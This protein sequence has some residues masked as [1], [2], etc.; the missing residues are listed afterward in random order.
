ML[1]RL[2]T[3][4]SI[5]AGH[6]GLL[7]QALR[8]AWLTLE[9]ALAGRS[10]WARVTST[11]PPDEGNAFRQQMDA[12]LDLLNLAG[13]ELEDADTRRRF[14]EQ[15][16]PARRAGLLTGDGANEPLTPPALRNDDETERPALRSTA[17]R[18]HKAGYP[19]LAR[20]VLLRTPWD[21]PLFLGLVE[22]F[23]HRPLHGNSEDSSGGWWRCLETI[24]GILDEREEAVIG[25][26]DHLEDA[27]AAGDANAGQEQTVE[28]LFRLGLDR[29]FTGDYAQAATHFTAALKLAPANASLYAHRGDAYR[30]RGEY[31]RAIADFHAAL[32]L[33][34]P[35][36]STLVSRAAAY[37]H[38]SEYERALADCNAALE[39]TPNSAAAY[40]VRA[41]ANASLGSDEQA[42]TDLTRAIALDPED[43]EARY[44]RGVL[45]TQKKE[46]VRAV[47]DF[48]HVLGRN[49]RHVAAYLHR[50]HAH[51]GRGDYARAVGDFSTVLRYHPQS[52]VAYSCRGLAHR[53]N[54]DADRAI[55][56]YTAALRLE[57]DNARVYY[58]R[59]V[60]YR[61][62]GDLTRAL[63]DLDVTI[64]LEPGHWAAHYH[65]SKIALAQGRPAH[66]LADLTATLSFNPNLAVAYLSRALIHDMLNQ[67][68]DAIED[69]TQA[70]Q[71]EPASPVA[72]LVRG[73]LYSHAGEY[74][75]AVADLS[76]A[77]R[78]DA[79][80]ALAYH[81]RA[82][83]C[84]LLG[85]HDRALADCDR[86]L[87]LEPGN[88]QG[89]AQ[90]S[91]VYHLLGK[92]PEALTDYTRAV[93][94]DARC[95]MSGWN[96]GLAQVE[97][98]RSTR[99]LGDYLDGLRDQSPALEPPP[100]TF[101]IVIEPP[102]LKP[103]AGAPEHTKRR[104][105]KPRTQAEPKTTNY[106]PAA[107]TAVA[108]P[109]LKK[110]APAS[111]VAAARVAGPHEAS[112]TP[113]PVSEEDVEVAVDEIL[114]QDARVTADEDDKAEFI[115]NEPISV[116]QA[117]PGLEDGRV[118][119]PSCHRSAVPSERLSRGRVRCGMCGKVFI[120]GLPAADRPSLTAL[121]EVRPRRPAPRRAA[122]APAGLLER[123]KKPRLL[124]AVGVAA[125]VLVGCYLRF[126]TAPRRPPLYP[127][128]GKASFEG[129]P[130]AN[131]NIVLE[132]AWAPQEVFPRPHAVVK[133]DG[134]FVVGTYGKDDG[135]P[136]GEYKVLVTWL[137]KAPEPE[138]EG[139]ALP[140]NCLPD[141]YARFDTSGLRVR[142]EPGENHIPALTLT[143]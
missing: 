34:P 80:L 26:V 78:L 126:F 21:E 64:R 37:H 36:P 124:A 70:V 82:V 15:I 19:Q 123:W 32:R 23:L 42:V 48:D 13:L 6:P 125:V 35:N 110:E 4:A 29:Y 113:A 53:L 84:T 18:L 116:V 86:H 60:L 39:I 91:I 132:P 104:T 16:R 79:R 102:E 141:K 8:R 97:R 107:D 27:A 85:A 127:A 89:Y 72:H 10:L 112:P 3:C 118:E 105:V 93:Q 67:Y 44:Q 143:R 77:I 75:A 96:Q 33:G 50:G 30:F 57:P 55:A 109:S 73:V 120:P 122:E 83:A 41:A 130:I 56:D 2:A 135:V 95:I 136:A 66:A 49:P 133:E 65:R 54:G 87:V 101:R 38:R 92:I 11:L 115:L 139:G 59:G 71:R 52:A 100:P 99:R 1:R 47:A 140:R 24:A 128:Q 43:D 131:A 94:L 31:E 69:G 14:A 17:D 106:H 28:C 40:R 68:G 111:P 114:L 137:V 98:L 20:A 117:P 58:C 119:C 74:A 7:W 76:E 62:G 63:A 12:L 81:E 9:I 90:R 45:L 121:A 51:R 88:A 5:P 61:R 142:I 134:S 103:A 25:L 108:Q 22:Y 138:Y 46:Y 129:T